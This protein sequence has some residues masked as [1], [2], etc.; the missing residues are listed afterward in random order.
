MNKLII[1]IFKS[2]ILHFIVIGCVAFLLYELYKPAATETIYI[3]TQ[4]ID[5]LIQQR[6]SIT[7][8]PMIEEE[9]EIL[10]A[11]HIEDEILLREAYKRGLN[12]NDY[13]VRKRLLNMMRSSLAEVIPEPSTA[14]LRAFY[15]ENTKRYQSSPSISFEHIYFSFV[16]AAQPDNPEKFIR[17]LNTTSDVFKL[18]EYFQIGNKLRK[19][20]FSAVALQFGKPFADY[21]FNLVLN[22]WSGPIESFHGTHFVIVS[23]QHQ[24]ELPKF[25]S[26]E[27]YLRNDYFML[28]NRE[29][30]NRKIDEMRKNYEII[31]EG[32]AK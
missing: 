12:E 11:G 31:V 25:E 26:I 21:V 13:R 28:K 9:K 1:S 19:T 16:N 20:S 10:I 8:N 30:Q 2:P 24:L 4:T 6:E 27:S 32:E 22:K 29:V 7:Q 3:T 14:Q 15:E 18:G 5:A 17:Q 23:E